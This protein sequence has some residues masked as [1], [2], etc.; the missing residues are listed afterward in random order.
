VQ[1]QGDSAAKMMTIDSIKVSQGHD[2][3]NRKPVFR[4]VMLEQRDWIMMRFG[5]IAS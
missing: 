1:F 2:P 3:E 5:Q 4:M